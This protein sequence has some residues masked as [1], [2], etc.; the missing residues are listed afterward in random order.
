MIDQTRF[1]HLVPLAYQ[2]CKATE[3]FVLTHGV[4]LGSRQ[5]ADANRAG[6]QDGSKI[7]LLLVD[8]IPLPENPE[9]AEAARHI[10]ILT[11][12]TRCV[13]FGHAVII[14][15][16]A[17]GDRELLVHNLVHIAQCER[18]GG[19]E[20]WVRHYLSNRRTCAQFSLGALEEEARGMAQEICTA[21]G[22]D[23]PLAVR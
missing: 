4:P 11:E 23:A 9:L 2:W 22:T 19:L 21:A 10:R 18:S 6:V 12:E 17:W 15:A 20:A 8:R 1:E 14:R 16:D 7:R 13:A 3:A 5:L